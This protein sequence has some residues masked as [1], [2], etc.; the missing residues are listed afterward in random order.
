MKITLCGSTTFLEE[1]EA[2]RE[3]LLEIGF[4]KA[5]LPGTTE[6]RKMIKKRLKERTKSIPEET[7]QKKIQHD[8]I[9]AHYKKIMRADCILVTN[10][11]KNGVKN[12]IGGNTLMEMGFAFVNKKPIF[13]LNPV[14]KIRYKSEILGM[15]P[16][17]INGN[18][19][20]IK[21]EMKND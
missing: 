17:V 21:E 13:L 1:M 10:F 6:I 15:Q 20:K 12:Y 7:A 9:N 14:P 18:L 4:E 19:E 5:Y 16:I 8:L 11:E 3:S 2:V